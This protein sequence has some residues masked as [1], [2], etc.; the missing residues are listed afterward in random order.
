M[1]TAR[2]RASRSGTGAAVAR[3]LGAALAVIAVTSGAFAFVGTLDDAPEPEPLAAGD[4]GADA[5]PT[6]TPEEPTSEPADPAPSPTAPESEPEA[7]DEPSETASDQPEPESEEPSE[8]P[9]TEP[10][11][12]PEPTS[13][14]PTE[15]PAATIP[16]GDISI[17]VLDGYKADGG[18]AMREVSE[19]LRGQGYRVVAENQALDYQVTTVLWT[20]GNEAAARQVAAAIGA[21][22]VRPQPGNLSESVTV[23]VVVGADRG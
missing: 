8:E 9:S 3:K 6:A 21:G 5:E 10:E 7:T 17:Q 23:H 19:D 18:V 14:Q 12:E 1:D 11:P 22:D 15:E 16:P 20:E 2:R 13:E 4:E